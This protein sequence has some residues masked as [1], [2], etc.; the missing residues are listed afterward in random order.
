MPGIP[1]KIQ[2]YPVQHL[3]II[4]AMPTNG[5]LGSTA[6]AVVLHEPCSPNACGSPSKPR[7]RMAVEGGSESFW[8]IVDTRPV[9]VVNA[10]EEPAGLIRS[11]AGP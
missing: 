5:A 6:C 3:P 4:K 1:P 8:A 11:L 10:E 2:V 9:N 7:W